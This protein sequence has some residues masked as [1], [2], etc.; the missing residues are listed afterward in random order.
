VAVNVSP[1]IATIVGGFLTAVVAFFGWLTAR[2]NRKV[3]HAIERADRAEIAATDVSARTDENKSAIDNNTAML[4]LLKQQNDIQART[5]GIQSEMLDT[6]RSNDAKQAAER[7]TWRASIDILAESAKTIAM[8][9]STTTG[10]V[11]LVREDIA[12]LPASIL[13]TQKVLVQEVKEHMDETL[14]PQN[15]E[16]K[17]QL[18]AINAKIDGLYKL[19]ETL[20]PSA[21][22]PAGEPPPLQVDILSMPSAP[23]VEADKPAE[24]PDRS[25]DKETKP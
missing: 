19:I 17:N 16:I 11:M 22:A 15:E 24:S 9:V 18:A 6:Q 14:S 2:T 7:E 4:S 21:D 13:E 3:D 12:R 25:T 5:V 10:N 20:I 8:A 1:E 23:P